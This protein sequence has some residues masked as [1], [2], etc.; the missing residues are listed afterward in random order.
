MQHVPA[1]PVL[2][3]RYWQLRPDGLLRSVTHRRVVWH[4]GQSLRARCLIG[5]HDAPASG[6][7]CGVHAEP[8]LETLRAEGVCLAPGEPLVVGQV[9][10]WGLV[11]SDGHGLR[12]QFA[13]PHRL[14]L[15]TP[16]SPPDA[17]ALAALARYG[18][19]ADSVP[20]A[21]ALG[22]VAAAILSFQSMSR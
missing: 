12:G 6:C 5:G 10:L 14:S 3:W 9:A 11:V 2:G 20:P 17:G 18:G 13:R 22:E 16:D 7:A 1:D 4:P 8:T 19:P 21:H 15:V